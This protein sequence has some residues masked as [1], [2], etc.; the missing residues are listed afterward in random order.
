MTWYSP[1]LEEKF[2][3]HREFHS[4]VSS[5][6]YQPHCCVDIT[7]TGRIFFLNSILLEKTLLYLYFIFARPDP[8]L[9]NCVLVVPQSAASWQREGFIPMSWK[10]M[11][12]SLDSLSTQELQRY[13]I[14]DP[15]E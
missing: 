13:Q 7:M 14:K 3:D 15:D 6:F 2:Q 1:H 5:K 11:E 9:T 10:I 12:M 8:P 4:T